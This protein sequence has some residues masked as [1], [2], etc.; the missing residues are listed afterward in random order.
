MKTPER[1]EF[2]YNDDL[3]AQ[4]TPTKLSYYSEDSDDE[5]YKLKHD[6][7]SNYK[8]SESWKTDSEDELDDV[9]DDDDLLNGCEREM[10]EDKQNQSFNNR[11]EKLLLLANNLI[12]W[13]GVER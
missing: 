5:P 2:E 10:D 11:H 4:T 6:D 7:C 12:N 13:D 1:A 8:I 3:Y 9:D